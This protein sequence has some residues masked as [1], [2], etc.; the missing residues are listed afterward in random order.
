MGQ[1]TKQLQRELDRHLEESN[2]NGKTRNFKIIF[3]FLKCICEIF[4]H[5]KTDTA[6]SLDWKRTSIK[7]TKSLR[8]FSITVPMMTILY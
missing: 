1:E 4:F 7:K 5:L 6:I 3:K 2:D 8:C